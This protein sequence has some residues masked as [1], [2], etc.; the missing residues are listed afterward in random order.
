MLEQL[1]VK[2]EPEL[3][4]W[5]SCLVKDVSD[6]RAEKTTCADLVREIIKENFMKPFNGKIILNDKS[7][8]HIDGYLGVYESS[9]KIGWSGTFIPNDTFPWWIHV[10]NKSLDP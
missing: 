4:E 7:E 3:K 5:L 8:H 1:N 2:I 6:A 10:S 9:G